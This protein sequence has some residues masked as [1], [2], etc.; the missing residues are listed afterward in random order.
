MDDVTARKGADTLVGKSYCHLYSKHMI[1]V[2]MRHALAIMTVAGTLTRVASD[3][4]GVGSIKRWG[5]G[6]SFQGYF[7]IMKRAP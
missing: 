1:H 4:R 2:Y 5:G 6:T 3:N 7:W